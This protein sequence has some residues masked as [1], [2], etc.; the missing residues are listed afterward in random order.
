MLFGIVSFGVMSFGVMSFGLL[1]VY[2]L[3]RSIST[4]WSML[5]TGKIGL[6]Y[7]EARAVRARVISGPIPIELTWHA[8]SFMPQITNYKEKIMKK[9][10]VS[11]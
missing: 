6:I 2:L 8:C 9:K 10:L 5:V 11:D 4:Y 1:S 3:C 7:R